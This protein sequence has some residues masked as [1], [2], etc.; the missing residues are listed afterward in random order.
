MFNIKSFI[1][2]LSRNKLYTIINILGLS[3]SLMFLIIIANYTV[4]NLT[5]DNWVEKADRI[6]VLANENGLGTGYKNGELLQARYP[7]IE[8]VCG[9]TTYEHSITI[10]ENKINAKFLFADTTFFN[11]FSIKTEGADGRTALIPMQNAVISKNFAN[12]IYGTTNPIGKV[13]KVFEKEY[14]ITGI[15]PDIENSVLKESDIVIRFE[16]MQY[17]N[18]T[19]TDEHMSNAGATTMFIMEKE[20]ADIR[21]KSDDILKYF[22]DNFWPYKGGIWKEVKLIPFKDIYFS[23]L[24]SSYDNLNK[25]EWSLVLILISVGI[26]ILLFAVVNY[27]NLTVAQTGFRAKE[28]ATR[29]LLGSSREILFGKLIFE[30]FIIC[31]VAFIFGLFLASAVEPYANSLLQSKISVMGSLNF[32]Y[33]ISYFTLVI[34]LSIISGIVPAT[35]ISNFKPIEVVRGSF[36]RK[37]SMVYSKI[38]ITFQNIITIALIGVS[39]TMILQEKH[40]INAPMGYNTKNILN[41]RTNFDSYGQITTFKN[42]VSQLSFV[43]DVALSEGT[44]LDGGNNNTIP[45]GKDRMVSFQIFKGDSIFFK[46]LGLQKIKENNLSGQNWYLNEQA[47]KELEINDDTLVVKLGS[48]HTRIHNI[49]GIYKDFRIENALHEPEAAILINLKNFDDYNKETVTEWPWNILIKINSGYDQALAYKSIKNIAERVSNGK[50]F[51]AKYIEDEL[52][53]TYKEE[54]RLSTVILIFTFIAV[55]ISSLGLLA[56]STYFIQQRQMEIAVR[57]VM[58]ST[59]KE[60]LVLLL[61]NFMRLLGIAFIIA[62]PVIWFT[63]NRWLTSYSYHINLSAWIFIAAGLFSAIVAIITVFWQSSKAANANPIN[64]IKS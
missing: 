22:K 25:G 4:N 40:L 21:A 37:T 11:F 43:E 51:S 32:K 50:E 61:K 54:Q 34:I 29:R 59:R 23:D 20:G 9:I 62:I 45:F 56:M 27:I 36:H 15:M 26:L 6:Y 57:K 39:L 28:M 16:N 17:Y 3:I 58:G 2:F 10:S 46:I 8:S 5:T 52:T 31:L 38:L 55:L 44:P 14:V 60:I 18:P 49:G 7:E 1:K 12:R 64:S 13:F 33:C 24:V 47:L 42:E 41:V 30:S 35:V 19:I 48:D 53:E 63:M